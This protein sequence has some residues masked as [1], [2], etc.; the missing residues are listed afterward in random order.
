MKINVIPVSTEE[1]GLSRAKRPF[2]RR[3]DKSKLQ[4]AGFRP[5]PEWKDALSRYMKEIDGEI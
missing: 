3:L 5:L 2:T 4:Q 1:Y